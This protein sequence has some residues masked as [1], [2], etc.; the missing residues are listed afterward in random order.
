MALVQTAK[1]K[2]D[3]VEEPVRLHALQ[4][5]GFVALVTAFLA[6]LQS[7]GVNIS[8][9]EFVGTV[10]F[11][12]IATPIVQGFFR[13]RKKTTAAFYVEADAADH[14]DLQP[15]KTHGTIWPDLADFEEVDL[16]KVDIAAEG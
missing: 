16:A 1:N 10:T 4:T 8:S 6:L 2:L 12:G 11:V 15:D 13:T 14:E 7:W 3:P 5:G 9:Q